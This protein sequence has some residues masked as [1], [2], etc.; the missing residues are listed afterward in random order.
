M[1][2][3]IM[4][5]SL[6][7]FVSVAA[8]SPAQQQLLPSAQEASKLTKQDIPELARKAEAGDAKA[9]LVLGHAYKY[10]YG[11]AKHE[12]EAAKWYRAAADQGNAEAQLCL[13]NA[14]RFGHGVRQD[15]DEAAK[16][17]LK[18]AE[19]GQI[20]AQVNLGALYHRQ[21]N[22]EEAVK[23]DRMAAEAGDPMAQSNLCL[24]YAM[25]EGVPRDYPTAYMWILLSRAMR[26]GEPSVPCVERD[27]GLDR[28]TKNFQGQI[29]ARLSAEE[30]AAAR[31]KAS[32][33]LVAHQ[34]EP[35]SPEGSETP[36]TV[37][38][39]SHKHGGRGLGYCYGWIT[40]RKDQIKYVSSNQGDGFEISPNDVKKVDGSFRSTGN[41]SQPFILL[42]AELILKNGKKHTFAMIDEQFQRQDPS[43]LFRALKNTTG[44]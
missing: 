28:D 6:I 16:W 9:Q 31:Q 19:Q 32:D 27:P 7:L 13:G 3:R 21:K 42:G 15:E 25:G 34:K 30:I 14:L 11:T 8:R 33:W 39:V 26:C 20:G 29:G 18:A 38:P 22:F 4:V 40:V 17:F 35:L 24:D 43:P 37:F 23:W 10:G 12:S 1:R 36:R 41:L 5:V 44:K 2:A